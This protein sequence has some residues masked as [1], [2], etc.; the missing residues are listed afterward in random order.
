MAQQAMAYAQPMVQS[1]QKAA[2]QATMY[3][4]PMIQSG[5]QAAQKVV[6]YIQ[7]AQK[8]ISSGG[9]RGYSQKIKIKCNALFTI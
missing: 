5:Q 4:Q 6:A 1:G 2:Q 9:S 7:A 3:T 8:P